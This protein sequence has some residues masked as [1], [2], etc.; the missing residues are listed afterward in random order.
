MNVHI[1]FKDGTETTYTCDDYRV[2]NGVFWIIQR[3]Y[4]GYPKAGIPLDGIKIFTER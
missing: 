2:E 4:S 1:Q 3:S